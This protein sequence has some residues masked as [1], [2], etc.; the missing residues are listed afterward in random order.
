MSEPTETEIKILSV[1]GIVVLSLA[2]TV[3]TLAT[4]AAFLPES[5][6]Y[7]IDTVKALLGAIATLA[8]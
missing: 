1:K 4:V 5:R 7:V 8:K 6:V 2:T 3:V